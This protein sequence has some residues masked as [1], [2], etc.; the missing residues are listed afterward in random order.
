MNTGKILPIIA[1]NNVPIAHP[2][3]GSVES[4]KKYDLVKFSFLIA[5]A[6]ISSVIKKPNKNLNRVLNLNQFFEIR[7]LT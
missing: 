2:K 6:K 3:N 4:T 1:P 5:K 7:Q